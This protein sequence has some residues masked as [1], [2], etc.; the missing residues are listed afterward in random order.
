MKKNI[1][2]YEEALT[3]ISKDNPDA[4]KV[5]FL[6][7][8]ASTEGDARA[9]YA[10][11]T[12]YLYGK[13]VKKNINKAVKLF[14]QAAKSDEPSA[15]YDLAVCYETGNGV[16]KNLK[17]AMEHYMRASLCGD[18]QSIYEVG[19]CYYYGIGIEKNRKL[20]WIWLDHA[21]KFNIQESQ[22]EHEE[23]KVPDS[24]NLTK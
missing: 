13:H 10:L 17:L 14:R 1:K 7:E 24:H 18:K 16:K 21:R 19:R 4:E 2:P 12:W 23:H 3:E 8:K 22:V 6:L 15:L 9:T 11:G 5:T 20:A